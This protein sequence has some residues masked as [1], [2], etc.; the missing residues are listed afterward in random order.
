MSERLDELL[1]QLA[2]A[3]L[4]RSLDG[5]EAAVGQ[6][7]DRW[8]S[9]ARATAAVGPVGVAATVL[10]LAIGLAAGGATAT[11]SAMASV[12]NDTFS[13]AAEIAPSTLLEG[14]P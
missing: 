8:Q 2:R 13:T 14:R 11:A 1:E 4:D 10:S 9:E 6:R 3:P 5:L 12:R 7:I